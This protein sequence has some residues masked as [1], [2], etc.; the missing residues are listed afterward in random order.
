MIWGLYDVNK[1]SSTDSKV[2]WTKVDFQVKILHNCTSKVTT[3]IIL[4]TVFFFPCVQAKSLYISHAVSNLN[5]T[6]FEIW[7]GF[8]PVGS[9]EKNNWAVKYATF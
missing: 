2:N 3:C 5:G 9:T 4:R 6:E 8:G 7:A 1:F